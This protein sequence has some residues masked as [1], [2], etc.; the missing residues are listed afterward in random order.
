MTDTS[1]RFGTRALWAAD[2]EDHHRKDV[3]VPIH[4]SVNFAYED[5]D[6]WFDVA[7]DQKPGYIYSRNKNPTVRPLELTMRAL[8]GAEEAI[9]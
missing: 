4:H 2:L 9:S 8:E 1:R 5:M 7:L 3:A 6:E